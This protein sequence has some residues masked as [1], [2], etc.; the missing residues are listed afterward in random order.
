MSP[1]GYAHATRSGKGTRKRG[2]DGA[3]G[4]AFS[5]TFTFTAWAAGRG[6]KGRACAHLVRTRDELEHTLCLVRISM[7][8][9]AQSIRVP[10]LSELMVGL[11]N[12][13]FTCAGGDL[14]TRGTTRGLRA[15]R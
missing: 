7:G 3:G 4:E 9:D 6:G 14:G 5:F 12:L 11:T 15:V 2:A 10:F 13:A 1:K 8:R